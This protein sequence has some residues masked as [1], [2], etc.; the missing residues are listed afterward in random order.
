M[1]NQNKG[2]GVLIV[3]SVL[4]LA[5]ATVLAVKGF[6]AKKGNKEKQKDADSFPLE[7]G[8]ENAKV[9]E[10]QQAIL[11]FDN[12]LL[13]TSISR[14]NGK[15]N[16]ATENAVKQILGKDKVESQDDIDAVLVKAKER[17]GGIIKGLFGV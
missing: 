17:A 8:S 16:I 11:K 6:K 4:L 2:T 14:D 5:G 1:E 9:K 12:R 13:G 3:I 10:L 7:L 15:F